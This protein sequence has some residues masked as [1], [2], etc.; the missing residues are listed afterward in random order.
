MKWSELEI[1]IKEISKIIQNLNSTTACFTGHRIQKLP[2]RNKED[3]GRCIALKNT[4]RA[5]IE[6]AVRRG[7]KTFL[8]GLA[9][10]FDTYCAEAV[11]ELKNQFPDIKLIGAIPCKNQDIKWSEKDKKRYKKLLKNVDGVRC[12]YEEYKGP[13][14]M[15]ERNKFMVNN[16]SLLIALYD[17]LSG[18]TKSTIDYAKKQGLDIIVLKP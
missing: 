17:G 5:E 11:L 10:G 15:L 2:W 13:E 18:G 3:D 9:L 16:S 1:S 12:I 6:K 14:C 7:Y 8:C 4:L